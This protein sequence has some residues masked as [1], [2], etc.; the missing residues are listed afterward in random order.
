[1]RL[2]VAVALRDLAGLA[3]ISAAGWLAGLAFERRASLPDLAV[4]WLERGATLTD[5]E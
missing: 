2:E 3:L 5:L 1:L 4:A